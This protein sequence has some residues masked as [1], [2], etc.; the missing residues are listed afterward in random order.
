MHN[1]TTQNR[2]NQL[3]DVCAYVRI[4]KK[5]LTLGEKMLVNQERA[6]LMRQEPEPYKIP[7]HIELKVQVITKTI[8]ETFWQRPDYI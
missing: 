8:K 7:P 4:E 5:V 3:Y 6:H 1:E 2:I